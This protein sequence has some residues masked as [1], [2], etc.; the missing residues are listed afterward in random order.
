MNIDRRNKLRNRQ[1][2]D[3]TGATAVECA[4][5]LPVVFLVLFALLDLGIAA[6][7][8]NAL[9]EASR[10]IAREVIIHGSLAPEEIGT[11]G[12][13]E[14]VGTAA[15][16]SEMVDSVQRVLPTMIDNQVKVRVSWTDND[17]S[18]RDHVRVELTYR[19][20]PLIP[21]LFVWGPV[22]LRSVT[23]M[24]IVN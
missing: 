9:A 10:R 12:P 19:H 18:P 11:W 20:E 23:T 7:R 3:R 15:D 8:Y 1:R 24:Q 21:A 5:V 17:N 13:V 6:I 22:D 2:T 16:I 14:Y 4:F